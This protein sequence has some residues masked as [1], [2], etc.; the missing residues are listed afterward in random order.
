MEN[1]REERRG[2]MESSY[3]DSLIALYGIDFKYSTS[4]IFRYLDIFLN[5]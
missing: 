1:E 4:F 2:T 3:E 5:I